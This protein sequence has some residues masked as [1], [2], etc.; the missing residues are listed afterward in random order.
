MKLIGFL[1]EFN[2]NRELKKIAP[3][4]NKEAVACDASQLVEQVYSNRWEAFFWIKQVKSEIVKLCGLVAKHRP[5]VILEIGTANG[6]SLFLF[7]KLAAKDAIIISI[8]LPAGK[9]G[10]GYPLYRAEFYKTFCSTGQQMHLLRAN[11]HDKITLEKVKEILAG[12]KIDFLFIDGDHTYEGVK[13]D[14][15]QYSTLTANDA[16]IALHDIARHRNGSECKVDEF[17]NEISSKYNNPIEF[18]EHQQQQWAGI[19]VLSQNNRK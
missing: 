3:S 14:F 4:L 12:R 10:G 16:V 6:G 8:D 2:A 19:G 15:E 7:T 1:H 5:R 11:S 9:F 13:H 17:W 18:I